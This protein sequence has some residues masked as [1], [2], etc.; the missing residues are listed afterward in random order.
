M[1]K[2]TAA[3]LLAN[4]LLFAA[5]L[6]AEGLFPRDALIFDADDG[7]N[8]EI[9]SVPTTGGSAHRLTDD[10]RFDSWWP[11][12]SPSRDKI[13]F[14][15]A[16]KGTHDRDFSRQTLWVM[17]ADGGNAHM[18]RDAGE[19]GWQAQGHAEWSPDGAQ[20]VMFGGKAMNLQIFVTD[21]NGKNPR[22]LTKRG[23]TN[24]DPSWSP[25]G[26][27][28]LFIG[29]PSFLCFEK[30][31]EVYAVP[32]R[33]GE[34]VRLTADKIR[35]NDPYYSPDGNHIAWLAETDARGFGGAGIWQIKDMDKPDARQH[36]V[37]PEKLISSK[38]QWAAD[39]NTIYYHRLAPG[40]DRGFRLYTIRRDGTG[41]AEIQT[42]LSGNQEYPGN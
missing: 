17:D 30:N 5:P 32:A 36:V 9:Y 6:H 19:D 38:P 15:R 41:M 8:Y 4:L 20:L 40:K 21:A 42:G 18:L 26:A 16:P 7:G 23:G 37:T 39:S 24:I 13:L 2:K 25:D 34:P 1:R 22:A 28:I 35:D 12:I 11:R 3:L 10:P 31:Y 14:Y 33:G 27:A 29:C